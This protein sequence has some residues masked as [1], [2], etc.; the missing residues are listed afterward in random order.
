MFKTVTP[1]TF[2]TVADCLNNVLCLQSSE[3]IRGLYALFRQKRHHHTLFHARTTSVA[4]IFI[5]SVWT[6]PHYVRHLCAP[7]IIKTH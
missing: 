4:A 7:P 3:D 1:F 5:S 2:L 6:G